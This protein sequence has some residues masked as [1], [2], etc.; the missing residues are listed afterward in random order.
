MVGIPHSG[1]K[2]SGF[3]ARSPDPCGHDGCWQCAEIV[4]TKAMNIIK[5]AEKQ[6]K[7][8]DDPLTEA[9]NRLG[10]NT[11][12]TFDSVVRKMVAETLPLRMSA[13]PVSMRQAREQ[14]QSEVDRLSREKSRHANE[15]ARNVLKAQG[16]SDEDIAAAEAILGWKPPQPT[17]REDKSVE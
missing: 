12:T 7:F 5:A 2:C 14:L 9:A 3:C 4:K 13:P 6:S 15:Q 11:S 10:K 17:S 8:K 1:N 16:A